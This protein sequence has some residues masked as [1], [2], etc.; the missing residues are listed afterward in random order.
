MSAGRF[1]FTVYEASYAADTRHPIRVQPETL[2]LSDGEA[3]PAT[4]EPP[5]GAATNPISAVASLGTRAGGLRPR[6]WNL[7]LNDETPPA[8]YDDRAKVALPILTQAF[9]DSVSV[10]SD[11]QYLGATWR[12]V[13][14]D[15][16]QAQ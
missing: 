8:G 11:V 3:T 10:N 4:N 5:T 16:E 15:A 1:T 2:E 9:Y 6:K 7:Q 13:S 12:L 14:K